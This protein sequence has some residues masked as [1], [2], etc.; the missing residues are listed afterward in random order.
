MKPILYIKQGCPWCIDAL[1]YFKRKKL[2]L[3]IRDVRGSEEGMAELEEVS[4][5]SLTP[6]LVHGNFLVA[7]FDIDEFEAALDRNPTA[8]KELGI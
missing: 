7:D 6:T 4:G 1:D 8:R 5:Q 3:D 2:D